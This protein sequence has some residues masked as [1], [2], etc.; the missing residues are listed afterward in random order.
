MA[1][2]EKER[3]SVDGIQPVEFQ[4]FLLKKIDSARNSIRAREKPI[5]LAYA[6]EG[7]FSRLQDVDEDVLLKT[8][9]KL[10]NKQCAYDSIP[11]WLLKMISGMILPYVTSMV[12]QYFPEGIVAKFWKSA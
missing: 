3:F 9:Q 12:N 1:L 10:P 11:T 7:G 5:Y 8:I 4:S 6:Q 2:V